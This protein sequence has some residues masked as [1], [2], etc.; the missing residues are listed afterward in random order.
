L[1]QSS[2]FLKWRFT[3]QN[4]R[5]FGSLR[6]L[7]SILVTAAALG[8]CAAVS[9]PKATAGGLSSEGPTPTN[10]VLSSVKGF[11]GWPGA[12]GDEPAAEITALRAALEKTEAR[13]AVAEDLQRR[14]AEADERAAAAERRNEELAAELRAQEARG[15]ELA[16][17]AQS[18][19]ERIAALS[20]Q[21]AQAAAEN[22]ALRGRLEAAEARAEDARRMEEDLAALKESPARRWSFCSAG[23]KEPLPRLME[24]AAMAMSTAYAALL[25]VQLA[26]LLGR[27]HDLI[28]FGDAEREWLSEE[29]E[30]TRAALLHR[31]G[32]PAAHPLQSSRPKAPP[33]Y[34]GSRVPRAA[35]AP[36]RAGANGSRIPEP[37]TQQTNGYASTSPTRSEGLRSRPV[38]MDDEEVSPAPS[39]DLSSMTPAEAGARQWASNGAAKVPVRSQIPQRPGSDSWGNSEGSS[40]SNPDQQSAIPRI[41]RRAQ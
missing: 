19:A 27:Q 3:A 30:S 18:M 10:A 13:A 12:G 23:S 9:Q 39:G 28:R 2:E 38:P 16:R 15:E 20:A 33:R 29:V 4:R 11:F 35:A 31:M 26:R 34:D 25:L 40:P 5:A 21:A 37:R 32:Q 24:L 36:A 22:E 7:L 1:L 41:R 17:R 8:V 6:A 14:L